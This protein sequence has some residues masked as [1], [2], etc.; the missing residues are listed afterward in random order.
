MTVPRERTF[1]SQM[2]LAFRERQRARSVSV[3]HPAEQ[4][5]HVVVF[6]SLGTVF[7]GAAHGDLTGAE[8]NSRLPM[9]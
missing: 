3:Q 2:S 7:M 8:F 4:R 9:Q 6:T 5:A 1:L